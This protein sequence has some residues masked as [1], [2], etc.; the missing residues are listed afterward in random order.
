MSLNS[1]LSKIFGNKSQRDLREIQPTVNAI[2]ALGPEMERLDNDGLRG[3]I[4]DVRADIKSAIADDENAIAE[5]RSKVD[6]LPF[7]ERQPLWDDIDRH[8]KNILDI[9]EK[10][11]DEHLPVVFAALRETAARFAHNETIVVTASQMDRDLAA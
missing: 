5:I 10:K 4:N 8:E 6:D 7:D 9:L 2:K 11:L 3:K 1:F